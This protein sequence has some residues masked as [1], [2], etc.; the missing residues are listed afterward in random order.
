MSL[1]Q[2]GRV[3]LVELLEEAVFGL[4]TCF[5]LRV[6]WLLEEFKGNLCHNPLQLPTLGFVEEPRVLHVVSRG[7]KLLAKRC[8]KNLSEKLNPGA[9]FATLQ[10]IWAYLDL[11]CYVENFAD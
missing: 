5:S 10:K 2:W 11:I 4:V 8:L 3:S 9:N 6:A 7:L 1:A